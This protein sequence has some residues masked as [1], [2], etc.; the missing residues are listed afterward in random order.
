MNEK[1]IRVLIKRDN[2]WWIA[3]CLEYDIAVQARTLKDVQYELERVFIGRICM[4]KQLGL[5]PFEGIPEA[6]KEF[7][8]LFE[9]SESTLKVELKSNKNIYNKIPAPYMLP[10]EAHMVLNI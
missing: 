3:Q 5:N 7:H 6:P 8:Q 2:E 10:N 9:D 4:A 1:M